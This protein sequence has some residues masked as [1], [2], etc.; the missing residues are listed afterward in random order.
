MAKEKFPTTQAIRALK[1]SGVDFSLHFYKFEEKGG[2]SVAAKELNVDEHEV[3]K[4]LVME[5]DN[6][7]PFLILMHGNKMV[8][9]KSLARSLGVKTVKP[10][11]PQIAHKHTGYFVGG[12]SPFG[13]RKS[14]TVYVEASIME[15][16]TMYINAGKKGLLAKMSP[17]DLKKIVTLT[18]VSV[19]I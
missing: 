16:S 3:I 17:G 8:S 14:L 4:T 15:L 12:I 13:T 19:A 10:C 18:P 6:G 1:E 7:E 2:T 11:E 9:T 5:S